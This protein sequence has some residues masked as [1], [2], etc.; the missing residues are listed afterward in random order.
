MTNLKGV[1]VRYKKKAP[2][3]T[4]RSPTVQ[5][6]SGKCEKLRFQLLLGDVRPDNLILHLAVLEE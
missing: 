6:L 1:R 2:P 3:N 5:V 4:R